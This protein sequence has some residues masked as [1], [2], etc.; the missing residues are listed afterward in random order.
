MASWS[1]LTN[2]ERVEVLLRENNKR[3]KM[4]YEFYSK[5]YLEGLLQGIRG[6]NS[7]IEAILRDWDRHE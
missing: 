3:L 4:N 1:K 7:G 5:D 6:V 2:K